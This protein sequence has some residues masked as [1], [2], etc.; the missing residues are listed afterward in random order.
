[1]AKKSTTNF[2]QAFDELEQITEWFEKGEA[3][4]DEG[5]KKF[6]RGLELAK[7]CK[8]KLSE[9]ENKIKELKKKFEE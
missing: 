2:S 9:V 1:M 5:L 6:E 8:E 7:V 4:L 3:D